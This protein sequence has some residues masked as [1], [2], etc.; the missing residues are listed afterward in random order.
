MQFTIVFQ[1][2]RESKEWSHFAWLATI[3]GVSFEYRT[4]LGHCVPLYTKGKYTANKKPLNSI[5]IDDG[6]VSI[7]TL[8][9]I[10]QC[11]FSDASAGSESFNDFCDNC[12]YSNDSLKALDTYRACMDAA[13]K[14]RTALG[15]EYTATR[16]RI[17]SLNS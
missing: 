14:L 6:Y 16:E 7:P 12:G 4:G 3:N 5:T 11:L 17:E 2:K 1:G 10:L 15:A 8:D 13:S 9:D